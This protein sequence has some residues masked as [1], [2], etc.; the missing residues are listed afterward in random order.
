MTQ[1][2]VCVLQVSPADVGG[3]A[4]KVALDLHR[5]L[6]E[7][8]M[9]SWLAVARASR[10][11]EAGLLAIPTEAATPAWT[12][13]LLAA[14]DRTGAAERPG[15]R[16]PRW[17]VDRA[18]RLAADPAH[19]RRVLSGLE[20]FDFPAT[21]AIPSL[22]PRRPDVL[23][24]HNLHG[25][26][27]DIRGL[28]AL[29]AARPTIL[30]MHDAWLLTGHC[31]YPMEC[32]GWRT[33]CVTC[34]YLDRPIPIRRDRAADNNRIKRE[35]LAGGRVHLAAPSRWL[36]DMAAESGHAALAAEVRVI[37]NG[38]DTDVFR[39]GDRALSRAGLG[40]P[41]DAL[42]VLFAARSVSTSEFKGFE[43]LEAALPAIA[44]GCDPGRELLLVALGAEGPDADLGGARVRFVPFVDD[45]AAVAEYYRAA[46]VY[47]HPSRAESFGLAVLEAMA[48]G[49]PVV[50]SNVGGI[51]EIVQD[52]VSGLLVA[53]G[54][55]DALAA[56][57][58][59][60][61]N[62]RD[63]RERLAAAG[64]QRAR[65]VFPF[66]RQVDAYLDWYAELTEDPQTLHRPMPS[67]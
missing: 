15:D 38:V 18:L 37:P 46:D 40:L 9:E 16:G 8:G 36:A 27:F 13:S 41:A 20:D 31:V 33:A 21:A 17:A 39:P 48:C 45:P 32:R 4:E 3:G 19:M 47:L 44:A 63:V 25:A 43:T 59:C 7:R 5:A 30:T 52:G 2:P 1:R 14:A 65:T 6:L 28:P 53:V 50:A 60:V 66:A 55:A 51:P 35:A 29:S 22:P 54:D 67:D 34:P 23:H 26:Y 58:L 62:D 56:A 57:A 42:I 61:L 24:L 64:A 11:D 10:A 49:T 12:R